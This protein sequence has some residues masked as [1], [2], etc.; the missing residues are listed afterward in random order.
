MGQALDAEVLDADDEGGRTGA[1]LALG[2]SVLQSRV[3]V[4]D[5]DRDGQGSQDVE[6]HQPVDE[7]LCCL[8]DVSSL[9]FT[10]GGGHGDQ[11][12]PEDEG[13]PAFDDARVDV[14]ELPEP[15][16]H[17]V[18]G[19]RPGTLPVAEADPVVVGPAA[20]EEDEG[21]EDQADHTEYFQRGEPELRFAVDF[22]WADVQADDDREEDEDPHSLGD[23]GGPVLYHTRCGGALGGDQDDVA[24]VV[25]PGGGEPQR[26]VDVLA[27]QMRGGA[28]GVVP[29]AREVAHH[30][31]EGVHDRVDGGGYDDVRHHEP[32]GPTGGQRGGGPHEQP[33]PDG[34]AQGDQLD[35]AGL[36]PLLQFAVFLHA[37]RVLFVQGQ[38]FRGELRLYVHEVGFVL[39][40]CLVGQCVAVSHVCS[41]ITAGDTTVV[42]TFVHIGVMFVMMYCDGWVFASIES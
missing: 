38:G 11:F 26:G 34:A 16:G 32:G 8:G 25:V 10:F 29:V 30:L 39:E 41:A 35:V 4:C 40:F 17:D 19:E 21:H 6:E 12:G 2:Q 23:G 1:W 42:Q 3:V 22:H 20:P 14:Q 15:A 33:G 9:V 24:V 31:P 37:R 36:E 13:E 5:Q 18:V 27:D 28:R 7:S